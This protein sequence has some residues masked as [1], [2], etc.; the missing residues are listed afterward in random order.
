VFLG[1]S[2]RPEIVR[3]RVYKSQYPGNEGGR[4]EGI[5]RDAPAVVAHL[6]ASWES[7]DIVHFV[8]PENH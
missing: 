2:F 7:L 8:P 5:Q 6:P 1:D 3:H 4:E